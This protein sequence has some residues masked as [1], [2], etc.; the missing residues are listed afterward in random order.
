MWK[1]FGM[2][3]GCSLVPYLWWACV[4]DQ[5]QNMKSYVSEGLL[6]HLASEWLAAE[7]LDNRNLLGML[8]SHLKWMFQF[9]SVPKQNFPGDSQKHTKSWFLFPFSLGPKVEGEITKVGWTLLCSLSVVKVLVIGLW[10]RM[11]LNW[12]FG[13]FLSQVKPGSVLS[14]QSTLCRVERKAHWH[15]ITNNNYLLRTGV[16]TGYHCLMCLCI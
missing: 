4:Q 16:G 13:K 7:E 2:L 6:F 12:G 5:D 1:E 11:C 14:N 15:T 9:Y 8:K 3:M 10:T